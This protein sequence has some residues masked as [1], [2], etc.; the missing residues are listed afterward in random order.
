MNVP[1]VAR[2]DRAEVLAD[3]RVA[4]HW[5]DGATSCFH[6]IW[7][8]QQLFHP[9]IGRPEQGPF[10]TLVLPD[11]PEDLAVAGC[12]IDDG[13]LVVDWANDG[14]V[15][16]HDLAWLRANAY[17]REQRLAR[18][19]RPATW[20]G[21]EASRFPWRSWDEAMADDAALHDLFAALRDHGFARLRGAPAEPGAVTR[22]AERFG[23][24]RMTDFG[25]IADIRTVPSGSG[26]RYA[27]IGSGSSNRL[28]P[29]TD[30]GWRY[31]PP[32]INF[33]LALEVTP[34]AGGESLL[35]DG[36]LATERL[37]RND[38]EAFAFLAAT[39]L[40]FAAE[41]N[42]RERYYAHGRMIVLDQDGEVSGV[43]F[44]DRTLGVQDLRED[45]IEPAYRA[46][47]AFA[48][49]LY[50]DDLVYCHGLQP[51]E[52]HVFDNHRVL[53]ARMAFDREAGPRHLQQC[54]VDR[55]EFHNR[56]RL[57]A[58]RLGRSDEAIAILPGGALG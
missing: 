1:L 51:G 25:A 37:R 54:S 20:T 58:R 9:A 39:P 34:G 55:E 44:S 6:F 36:L 13:A 27:N 24:I 14:R 45:L 22:L 18:K 28:G 43:R 40:R 50:A 2:A 5:A 10:D 17:D 30:E 47:R 26:S 49:E 42:D 7:L 52:M 16:R 53:H 4:L 3:R 35:Y 41:R 12:R 11:R 15:T 46:L 57:L 23:P 21:Q 8:R 19:A 29:H 48:A 33:H 31:A 32:G 56:L 38:P